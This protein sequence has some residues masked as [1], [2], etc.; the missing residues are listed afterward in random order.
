MGLRSWLT[1]VDSYSE[2]ETVYESILENPGANGIHYVLQLES[3]KVAFPPGT[4][5]VAWSGDGSSTVE[6]LR[7]EQCLERTWLL[8]NWLEHFPE[9]HDEPGGPTKYGTM[10]STLEEIYKLWAPDADSKV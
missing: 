1:P 5:I 10:L 4:V 7:P 6:Q 8:D 9:Y 3:D 2:F